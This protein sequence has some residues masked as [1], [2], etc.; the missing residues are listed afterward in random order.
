[1]ETRRYFFGNM[2]LSSIQ[3]GIQYGH[4]V[5]RMAAKYRAWDQG[6]RPDE[7]LFEWL[8]KYETVVLLNAGYSDELYELL[9]IFNDPTN[10]YPFGYFQESK[11]ALDGAMTCVGIVLPHKIYTGA[12]RVRTRDFDC[13][14]QEFLDEVQETGEILVWDD[15]KARTTQTIYPLTKWEYEMMLRLNN[16]GLAR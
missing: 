10:P 3:Q 11:E 8:E 1:V 12:Q 5:G 13:S 16:Y 7:I 15:P 14:V 6:G 9:R 4:T 2:Y